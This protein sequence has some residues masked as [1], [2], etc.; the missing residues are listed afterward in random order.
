MFDVQVALA[1]DFERPMT[2]HVVR[3]FDL[4]LE[5]HKRHR[6]RRKWTIH[7]FRGKP[8]L[9]QQLLDAGFDLSFGRHYNPEAF[10]LTPPHRRHRESDSGG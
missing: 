10:A 5:A 2:L 7:G 4:I 9:A 8:A 3:A 1:E 6:P